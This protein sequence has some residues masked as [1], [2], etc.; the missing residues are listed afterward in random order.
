MLGTVVNGVVET[1]AETVG[2]TM[3]RTLWHNYC[4]KD[5]DG[6]SSELLHQKTLWIASDLSKASAVN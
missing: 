6:L 2:R 5:E 1:S 4:T 3:S